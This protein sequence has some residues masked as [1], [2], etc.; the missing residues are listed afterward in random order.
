[1]SAL[2]WHCSRQSQLLTFYIEL[3]SVSVNHAQEHA[4]Q[5]EDSL[6]DGSLIYIILH[7]FSYEAPSQGGA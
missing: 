5:P 3:Y 6:Q 2:S 1:M 4:Q 7:V